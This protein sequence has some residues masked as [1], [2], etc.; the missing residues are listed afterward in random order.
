[1]LGALS[2]RTRN[3]QVALYQSGEVDFLV[4]TDAI[5]MGLNMDID[6]I[7]FAASEKF[8]GAVTRPLRPDELGQIAGRAGRHMNDGTFGLTVECNEIDED[9]IVRIEAHRYEPVRR[10]Q[11]RNSDL[12]FASLTA[13][14]GSLEMPPPQRG[15]AKARPAMDIACLRLL[16]S[17]ADIARVATAPAA[18]KLLWEVCQLPDFRKL[19]I[20]DHARLVESIYC[21][22]V[23]D[24]ASLPEDW[25]ARHIARLDEIEGDVAA[26][27]GRLAQ[28]R[29]WTYA[30]HRPGWVRDAAHWQELTRAVEDRLSDALHERLTQR[31]VDRRT[32]ILLRSLRDEETLRLQLDVSG[33]ALLGG[34]AIGKIEGFRFA[35]DPRAEGFHGRTLRAAALKGLEIAYAERAGRLVNADD[36]KIALSDHGRLRWDGAPVAALARGNTPFDPGLTLFCDDELRS[37]IRES[38]ATRLGMWLSAR[39]ET[40]LGP[41]TALRRAADARSGTPLSLRAGARGI[42]HQICEGFGSLDRRGATLPPDL[43]QAQ[44][45]LRPFGVR[46]GRHFAFM[47]HLLRPGA[48][49]LLALLWCVWA[50]QQRIPAPP[51]AG[52]TSC[53]PEAWWPDG[54]LRAAGYWRVGPRAIRLDIV[55]RLEEALEAAARS[56]ST[57]EDALP[58]LVSL[59]GSSAAVLEQIVTHLG[60]IQT[61]VGEAASRVH[62]WRRG[63]ARRRPDRRSGGRAFASPVRESPFAELA[64]FLAGN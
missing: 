13:L 22:L 21:H 17:R 26:L 4:A 43:R 7:A 14:A 40:C 50:G 10:L 34:E 29:T 11:W 46:F 51:A 64:G 61:P 53:E 20:E 31:F 37:D 3:A 44:S 9:T 57:S 5:G 6:H 19:S 52:L 48:A 24:E 63:R 56:G 23:G 1:V 55:E 62:V 36:S 27:S 25:L 60:W 32:A 18:V 35:P 45:D 8:D 16:A 59:L 33:A 15:F 58:G 39:V 49:H 47:P 28:I 2:P 12:C 54:F 38:I 30:A 42:A 41:L